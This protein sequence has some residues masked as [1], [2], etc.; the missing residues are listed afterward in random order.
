MSI[1]KNNK[2]PFIGDIDIDAIQFGPYETK[3]GGRQQVNIYRDLEGGTGRKNMFNEVNLCA[4]VAEP[5]ETRYPL[6]EKRGDVFA[7]PGPGEQRSSERRGLAIKVEDPR[8][9][10]ALLRL[11]KKIVDEAIKQSKVWFKRDMSEE[12]VLARYKPVLFKKDPD[13]VNDPYLMKIKVKV[14]GPVPTE[15]K[16]TMPSGRISKNGGRPEHLN[17]GAHVVPIVSFSYGLWFMG[18]GASFGVS[19]QAEN[20]IVTPGSTEDDSLSKFASS[21]P[22]EF[23]DDEPEVKRQKQDFTGHEVPSTSSNNN[24]DEVHLENDDAM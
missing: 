14:G 19:L 6:D 4:D 9:V 7:E 5:M 24:D 20:M 2:V 21:V 11:D 15:L 23:S 18:G 13:N 10:D 22:L 17:K 8:A 1:Q 16:L 12:Q 3:A